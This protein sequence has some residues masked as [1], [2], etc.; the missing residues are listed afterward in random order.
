MGAG[1]REWG[2]EHEVIRH[3]LVDH[4]VRIALQTI[5]ALKFNTETQEIAP[6]PPGSHPSI[7]DNVHNMS[8]GQRMHPAQILQ[9]YRPGM[10]IGLEPGGVIKL[11]MHYTATGEQVKRYT[12][13]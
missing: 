2:Q 10:A 5:L 12:A 4:K 11:Q 1:R 8:H 9:V 6:R 3:V 7:R 13:G